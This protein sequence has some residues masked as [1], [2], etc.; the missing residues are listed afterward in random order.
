MRR[1]WRHSRNCPPKLLSWYMPLSSPLPG[2]FAIT[3]EVIAWLA[4][5]AHVSAVQPRRHE[6]IL[7]NFLRTV[8][9]LDAASCLGMAALVLP[10]AAALEAPLGVDAAILT[11]AA[12]SLVP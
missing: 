1:R 10:T 5:S 12:A 3:S 8:L 6:M 9:K 2:T 11:A 4:A 7:S